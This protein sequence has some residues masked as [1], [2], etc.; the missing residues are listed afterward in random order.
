MAT[1][2]IVLHHDGRGPLV[3]P[4]VDEPPIIFE[5]FVPVDV[6]EEVA[7]EEPG[8]WI[9]FV[10]EEGVPILSIPDDGRAYRWAEEVEGKPAHLESRSLGSGLLAHV[11]DFR[12]VTA[13]KTSSRPGSSSTPPPPSGAEQN[14]EA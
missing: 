6:P 11:D 8:D 14:T 3:H 2:S 12:R 9:P 13:P 4:R 5:P 10:D 1:V 7:G